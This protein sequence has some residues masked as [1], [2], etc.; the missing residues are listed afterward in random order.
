MGVAKGNRDAGL[1]AGSTRSKSRNGESGPMYL[2]QQRKLA[3]H[4]RA[5][6]REKY[7]VDLANIVIDQPPNVE[8]GEFALPLSFELAKRLR[9][10][11]RKIAEEIVADFPLPEGF[12]KLEVAGA[13]YI[14]ARLKRDVAARALASGEPLG[15]SPAKAQPT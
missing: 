14:N 2:E 11:P 5:F 15:A 6:L 12:D 8:M 13:G 10:A 4:V 7:N 1:K 3:S 9:K